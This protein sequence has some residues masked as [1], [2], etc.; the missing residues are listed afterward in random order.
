MNFSS[1]TGTAPVSIV[2]SLIVS[3][4]LNGGNGGPIVGSG[5]DRK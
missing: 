5:I 3:N 1:A 2:N 4:D